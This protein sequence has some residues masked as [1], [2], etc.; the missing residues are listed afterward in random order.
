MFRPKLVRFIM[1]LALIAL[2][3]PQQS[4]VVGQIRV[5]ALPQ[6][7]IPAPADVGLN[8]KTQFGAA[9]DGVTDDTDEIKAALAFNRADVNLD[10]FGRPSLLFFPAGTYLVSDTLAWIGCCMTLQGEGTASSIIKLKDSAAGFGSVN[11]PKAVIFTPDGNMSFRQNIFDLTVNTGSGNPGAIGL[12][13]ISNNWGAIRGVNVITA[14]NNA[15][16]GIA[17]TRSWPGPLLIRDT[18]VQG[19]NI[20]IDI[21]H[22]EYGPV[23]ENIVLQGQTLAGIRNAGNTITIRKLFSTNSVPALLNTDGIGS[24]IVLDSAL[25]GG[26]GS[27]SALE[28]VGDLFVRNV[29]ASGYASVIK[30]GSTVVPG[31]SVSEYTARTLFSQFPTPLRTLSLPISELPTFYE[32]ISNWHKALPSSSSSGASL[33][34]LQAAFNSGKST[35]YFSY[36]GSLWGN[37]TLTVPTTVRRIVLF[38]HVLN[39]WDGIGLVLRVEDNNT[40]PLIIEGVGYGLTVEHRG[41]RPLVLKHGGYKY[42]EFPGAGDLHLDDV[43]IEPV[44][45]SQPHRIWAR[46]LNT[47]GNTTRIVNNGAQLWIMGLKTEGNGTVIE[48]K[49]G[50]KTELF[51]TLL[52]PAQSVPAGRAAFINHESSVSL[53][54]SWSS[55]ETNGIFPIMVR[56]T[57]GGVTRELLTSSISGRTMPLYLGY[58]AISPD[59]PGLYNTG[60][61]S[62]R[63]YNTTGGVNWS[64]PFGPS[65]NPNLVPLMGDWNGDGVDTAGL[66]VRNTGAWLLSN[67]NVSVHQSFIYGPGFTP[68][69]GD[70][71]GNGTDNVG[72]YNPANSSWILAGVNGGAPTISFPYG[73]VNAI[74]LTGDWD[75]NG[76]DTP[77]IFNPANGSFILANALNAAPFTAFPYGNSSL[78][79]ME[80]DWDANGTDTAGMWNP[81]T[82]VWLL[83][84]QNASI[85][86]QVTYTYGA[87]NSALIPLPGVWPPGGN[88]SIASGIYDPTVTDSTPTETPVQEIAPTFA[89]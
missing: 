29:T 23:F 48:T 74:P 61:W 27:R 12:D 73:V 17:L 18:G 8:V 64:F 5:N 11:S 75:G 33:S 37:A 89:P 70:W 62:L 63:N 40:A 42:K 34:A 7:N 53:I 66:Y 1:L 65:N 4:N 85:A 72:V 41:S 80:G 79:P 35:I 26:S 68:L 21:K 58:R 31:L 45:F 88:I 22:A 50:G 46:Q 57:R 3:I 84:N 13:Y 52:Y 49:G 59:T 16:T 78:I 36:G 76:T 77:G 60:M 14:D 20:G 30:T 38:G 6:T 83:I 86:P 43:G 55:Y 81:A 15:H 67:D 82:G 56:E 71:D 25:N 54:Y 32:P 19:F 2:L 51:G 47:E 87:G 10:Y 28:N 39:N 44:T 9:G 69:V 24:A